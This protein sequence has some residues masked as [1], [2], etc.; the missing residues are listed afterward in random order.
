MDFLKKYSFFLCFTIVFVACT[1]ILGYYRNLNHAPEPLHLWRKTDGL[2][3]IE[4]YTN[5]NLNFFDF[6]SEYNQLETEGKAVA[7]FPLHYYT[8]AVLNKCFGNH[9]SNARW[10]WLLY[11]FFGLFCLAKLAYKISGNFVFGIVVGHV[12]FLS[13]VF[14]NY[15]LEFLP[16]PIA[17]SYCCMGLYAWYLYYHSK[18]KKHMNYATLALLLCGIT[19]VYFLIPA[20]AVAGTVLVQVLLKKV[21][22]HKFL[23]FNIPLILA[24]I[25][26]LCWIKFT[27]YY[28]T[29]LYP[30]NMF[31]ANILPYWTTSQEYIDLIFNKVS[32]Q[33]MQEYFFVRLD[34]FIYGLAIL[35]VFLT[36]KSKQH[37]RN[38]TFAGFALLGGLS[39]VTLFFFAF[40]DHDYYIYPL[41][42]LVPTL[43]ILI[44]AQVKLLIPKH[45]N[46]LFSTTLGL[47]FVLAFWQYYLTTNDTLRKDDYVQWDYSVNVREFSTLHGNLD[48]LQMKEDDKVVILSDNSPQTILYFMKRKGWSYNNRN[49]NMTQE[50]MIENGAK[51]WFQSKIAHVNIDTTHFTITET[52][53][54][55][56][57]DIFVVYAT[58][59]LISH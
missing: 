53:P 20:I 16:D 22:F 15:S 32:K 10:V 44:G 3:Q 57:D 59:S 12:L 6:G 13:H 56:E 25:G 55:Y 17:F 38:L 45:S 2:S 1:A 33:W 47:L 14:N 29:E 5:N 28:N 7:E 26:S 30:N 49:Y 23:K 19:K 4:R 46:I 43:L 40:R 52:N 9:L 34:Y 21:S 50:M 35:L 42:F 39:F 31:L 8:V 41:F 27:I 11:L 37:W 54:V 36:Y 24:G 48:T 51:F 18:E 58:D